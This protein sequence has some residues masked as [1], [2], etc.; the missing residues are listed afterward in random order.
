MSAMVVHRKSVELPALT[1]TL[2]PMRG[3]RA[4]WSIGWVLATI[5]MV[6]SGCEPR[7]AQDPLTALNT[8]WVTGS[9]HLQ[10]MEKLDATAPMDKQTLAALKNIVS[11][12]SYSLTVREA[13]LE[14]LA[15]RDL[16][17]LKTTIRRTLPRSANG[18]W[19]TRVSQIIAQRGWAD[20][21]PA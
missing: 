9:Q 16:N 8:P 14:R 1:A 12:D 5:A 10:A 19:I 20:L 4:H 2:R 3:M 17:E 11:R 6:A 13:A 15:A 21:S 18:A 7:A